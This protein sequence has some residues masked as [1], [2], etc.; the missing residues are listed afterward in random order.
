M[1]LRDLIRYL[2][3][4]RIMCY[5]VTVPYFPQEIFTSCRTKYHKSYE[6]KIVVW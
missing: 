5:Q 1:K 6:R 4:M 2:E 3:I